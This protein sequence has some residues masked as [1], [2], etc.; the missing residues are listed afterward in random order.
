[1]RAKRRVES[2]RA[3]GA[4]EAVSGAGSLRVHGG[5]NMGYVLLTPG[6]KCGA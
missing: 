3:S 4:V 2:V 1:M 6:L 5:F